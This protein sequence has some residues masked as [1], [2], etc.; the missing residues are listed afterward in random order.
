MQKQGFL[1]ERSIFLAY[2][3]QN[4]QDMTIFYQ[5][6]ADSQISSMKVQQ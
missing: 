3:F 2:F 4:I 6:S 5:T 1:K